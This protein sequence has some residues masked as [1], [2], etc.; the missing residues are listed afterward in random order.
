MF[1]VQETGGIRVNN[2]VQLALAFGAVIYYFLAFFLFGVC[3]TRHLK[4]KLFSV[5]LTLVVGMLMYF[6]L[7]ETMALPMKIKG[8]PL[9]VLGNAWFSTAAVLMV[10]SLVLNGKFLWRTGKSWWKRKRKE[11]GFLIGFV[12]LILV[13]YVLIL[14]LS[15]VYMGVR[16]DYYYIGDVTTSVYK[17]SIQQYCHYNGRKLERFDPS[18]FIPMYPMHSAALCKLTGLHP[19]IENKWASLFVMLVLCNMVYYLLG[20]MVYSRDWK[21][22]LILL[23][24]IAAIFFQLQSNGLTVGI[25]YYYRLSEGKG[26]LGNLILPGIILF[27]A[28]IVKDSDSYWNWVLLL[29]AVMSGYTIAMSS[30]FLIPVSLG[31]LFLAF[32]V[33][34]RT[35]RYLIHMGICVIPCIVVLVVYQLSLKGVIP[36]PIV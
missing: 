17:D 31:C 14:S 8:Q 6:L 33:G 35:G 12:L 27:F 11:K 13:Q 30:M 18:Y 15:P 36:L 24:V 7:F 1:L 4:D 2:T 3:I 20:R 23:A 22:L 26:V 19:I 9:H 32:L 16:D 34:K 5:S 21:K 29:L 25:F 10:L 28:R